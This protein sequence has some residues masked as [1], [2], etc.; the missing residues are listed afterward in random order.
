MIRSP[1][2]V[3]QDRIAINLPRLWSGRFFVLVVLAQNLSEC[4][5]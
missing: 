1:M 5:S 4:Q 3:M 2:N